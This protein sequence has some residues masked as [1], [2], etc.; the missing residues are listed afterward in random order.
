MPFNGQLGPEPRKLEALEDKGV[1]T[2]DNVL[3]RTMCIGFQLS[4]EE[5]QVHKLL[6]T[7]D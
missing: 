3:A 4:V 2:Q 1:G 7:K 6:L 5:V